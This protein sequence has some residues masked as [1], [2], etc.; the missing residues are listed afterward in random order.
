MVFD[1]ITGGLPESVS[2]CGIDY[3]IRSD[4]T[5]GILFDKVLRSGK[6]NEE[7][8]IHMLELYY[9]N[10]PA[11]IKEA[12]ERILWF[13]HCGNIPETNTDNKKRYHRKES[14]NAPYALSQDAAYIYASFKEQ[15]GIDLTQEKMHWWKFMALF[16]SLGEDTKMSK[17]MYYRTVSTSGLSKERRAF[18]NDMKNLYKIKS[19]ADESKKV[20][21][22][23]RNQRW[24][25]YVQNRHEEIV[26]GKGMAD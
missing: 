18:I 23:M 4:F 17:I 21:L 19:E 14:S 7:I 12:I 15:Y 1:I 10:I 3:P 9:P 26:E 25:D 16:E 6:T 20:T 5:V 8:L 22:D 13:Y 11:N 2:V 24:K